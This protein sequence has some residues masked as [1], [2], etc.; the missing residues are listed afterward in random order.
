MRA[1]A[2]TSRK[3]G[4]VELLDLERPKPAAGEVLIEMLRRI[5]RRD[6]ISAFSLA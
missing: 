2:K 6:L 1:L 3:H 5:A 4:Y